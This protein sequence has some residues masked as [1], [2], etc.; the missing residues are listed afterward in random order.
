MGLV[1]PTDT[2]VNIYLLLGGWYGLWGGL[3]HSG[4]TLDPA[5]NRLSP[6]L[7]LDVGQV[8]GWPPELCWYHCCKQIGLPLPLCIGL[9][10]KFWLD[11]PFLVNKKEKTQKT[12]HS[13]VH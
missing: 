12:H 7:L 11:F 1:S 2:C 5:M 3:V 13:I 4:P 10:A 8:M 9:L 6:L